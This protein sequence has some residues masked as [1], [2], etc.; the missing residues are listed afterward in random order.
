MLTSSE[1]CLVHILFDRPII[2]KLIE[3]IHSY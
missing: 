1:L 3:G 2:L